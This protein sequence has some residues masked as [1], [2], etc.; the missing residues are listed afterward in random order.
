MNSTENQDLKKRFPSAVD[1]A[2]FLLK[3]LAITI[4]LL[5]TVYTVN[6]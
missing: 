6:R 5:L 3:L 1:L 4:V 2:D